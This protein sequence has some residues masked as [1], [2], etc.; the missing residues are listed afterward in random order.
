MAD[1][2]IAL[3]IAEGPFASRP[4][5]SAAL[6]YYATDTGQRFYSNGVSWVEQSMGPTGVA[7]PSGPTGVR[8]ITGPTGSGLTGATGVIGPT[9]V[10]GLTG[11]GITGATGVAGPTGSTG[12]VGATGPGVGLTGPTGPTGVT[13]T[14]VRGRVTAAGTVGTGSGF[15]VV[16]AATGKYDLSWSPAFSTEPVVVVTPF[17]TG[18]ITTIIAS[19]DAT[20]PPTT[21]G[22]RVL[23]LSGGGA[24]FANADFDFHAIGS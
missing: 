24:S 16:R 7:G 15:S 17:D 22:V 2:E 14:F 21:T 13:P 9:G 12:V 20:Q 3:I 8:G 5:A 19:I 18:G 11:A 6:E 23:T 10:A 1:I 4:A